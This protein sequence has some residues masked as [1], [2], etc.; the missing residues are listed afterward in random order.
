MPE[1]SL[2]LTAISPLDG[3]YHSKT[4]LLAPF[5][6]EYA[7][8]AFFSLLFADMFFPLKYQAD[9]IDKH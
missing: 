1:E 6:S 7:L 9:R 3:R 4:K 2:A 5:F 8:I